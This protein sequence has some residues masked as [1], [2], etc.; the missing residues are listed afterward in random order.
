MEFSDYIKEYSPQGDADG[1]Q[2]KKQVGFFSRISE[3]HAGIS[4]FCMNW[5]EIRRT[6]PG[7]AGELGY[8]SPVYKLV[9]GAAQS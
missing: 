3:M 1:S 9:I 8:K 7:Q 6:L 2:G 4:F 5:K